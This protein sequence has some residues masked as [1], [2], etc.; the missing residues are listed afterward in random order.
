MKNLSYS[1][2]KCSK[3]KGETNHWF[4]VLFMIATEGAP[5]HPGALR[6][7][8]QGDGGRVHIISFTHWLT[9][10]NGEEGWEHYCGQ[11]C[12]MEAISPRLP[13]M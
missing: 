10:H 3:V 2:D 8:S 13:S 9:K 1:C 4:A 5:L 6:H 7:I 12:L 11:Q